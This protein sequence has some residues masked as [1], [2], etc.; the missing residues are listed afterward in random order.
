MELLICHNNQYDITPFTEKYFSILKK[1]NINYCQISINDLDFWKK[2]SE[3]SHFIYQWP[4]YN[5]TSNYIANSIIP[6]IE[7]KYNIECFPNSLSSWLYD[8]KIK[9][10]FL[11]DSYGFPVVKTWVFFDENNAKDQ[12]LSM[13]YPIVFKLIGGASSE[14][15]VL[16]KNRHQ[17]RSIIRRM[18]KKGISKYGIK[19]KNKTYNLAKEIYCRINKKHAGLQIWRKHKNYVL[20]QEFLPDNKFDTRITIIGN[21]AFGFRR[22]NRKNDFRASGSGDIDY[23]PDKIDHR[24]VKIAFEVSDRLNFQSM[25]Y[26]FLYKNEEPQIAEISY[27]YADY[28]IHECPGYWN[29][30]MEWIVGRNWPQKLILED[31]LNISLE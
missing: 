15:V 9:E 13:K 19:V 28:A 2:I 25:A 30:K 29:S 18:F 23:D 3:S 22:H 11:L 21:R 20:F 5:D 26:D 12:V 27:A 17:A 6:V 31:L 4:H 16:I 7:K 8:D 24:C 14:N 10:Y 1:N